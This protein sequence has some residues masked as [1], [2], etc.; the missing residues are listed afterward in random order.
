ME[1]FELRDDK[2]TLS[3]LTPADFPALIAWMNDPSV[4][5]WMPM[6]SYPYNN[7]DAEWFLTN[8]VKPGW[9]TGKE[10]TWAIRETSLGGGFMPAKGTVAIRTD[11]ILGYQPGEVG[12]VLAP[13]A[14]GKG[15][16]SAALRLVL[17]YAFDPDGL[18]LNTARWECKSGNERSWRVA[19]SCGFQFDGIWPADDK[20]HT[21][22][23]WY[24][25]LS[26]DHPLTATTA[27]PAGAPVG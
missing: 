16:A 21:P 12:F 23:N 1:P 10:L 15:L 26:R 7:A 9:A 8:K 6:A 25:S 20:E 2:V 18:N 27:W 17:A 13:E 19:W 3:E 14:R 11:K 22:G 5:R 4:K 24:A